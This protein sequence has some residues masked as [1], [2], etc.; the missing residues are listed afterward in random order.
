MQEFNFYVCITK[1]F[2]KKEIYGSYI[3]AYISDLKITLPELL[4]EHL[5]PSKWTIFSIDVWWGLKIN[6]L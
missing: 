2:F 6:V 3:A 5:N 4:R 1:R